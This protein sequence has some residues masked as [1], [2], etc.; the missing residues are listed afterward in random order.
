M[1]NTHHTQNQYVCMCGGSDGSSIYQSLLNA[2]TNSDFLGSSLSFI[3][4]VWF[5][6]ID[7]TDCVY[8][9]SFV[10]QRARPPVRPLV[11]DALANIHPVILSSLVWYKASFSTS[12]LPLHTYT[13]M[14]QTI[15]YAELPNER[16]EPNTRALTS[17]H[18]VY[19]C[20]SSTP[21]TPLYH[22]H[23]YCISWGTCRRYLRL[24][25]DVL[26]IGAW[27]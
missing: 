9:R 10:H 4:F 21:T 26:C 24:S 19:Q 16:N 11:F 17:C 14:H 2:Y 3:R 8:V 18:R 5:N 25:V 7:K 27:A 1:P 23:W 15:W 6:L 20:S 12:T 13:H 22:H